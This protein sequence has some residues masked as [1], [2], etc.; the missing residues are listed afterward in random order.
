MKPFELE[1]HWKHDPHTGKFTYPD[2]LQMKCGQKVLASISMFELK[3]ALDRLQ[4]L[5]RTQKL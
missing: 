4:V 5:E 1:V 2:E 3:E